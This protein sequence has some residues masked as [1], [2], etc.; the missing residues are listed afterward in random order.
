M[1]ENRILDCLLERNIHGTV[2][3]LAAK[4]KPSPP[5]FAQTKL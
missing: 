1:V 4:R 2:V 5:G 3:I